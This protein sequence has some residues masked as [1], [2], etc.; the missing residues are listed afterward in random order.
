MRL[1][2]NYCNFIKFRIY[3]LRDSL[4]GD[5]WKIYDYVVRHFIGTVSYN[6]KYMATTLNVSV[7]EEGFSFSGKKLLEPGFT[8]VMTW[9]VGRRVLEKMFLLVFLLFLFTC[10]RRPAGHVMMS[11]VVVVV[12]VVGGEQLLY[13]GSPRAH[14]WSQRI[15]KQILFFCLNFYFKS[16]CMI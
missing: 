2:Q 4:D 13:I 9:Q 11:V 15:Q 7:G 1:T 6:C 16:S 14:V 5:A 8:A 3:T 12:V 10:G